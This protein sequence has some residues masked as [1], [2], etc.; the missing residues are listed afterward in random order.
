M[1]QEIK[2]FVFFGHLR[3][4]DGSMEYGKM[5]ADMTFRVTDFM[6][7]LDGF[8]SFFSGFVSP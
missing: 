5:I 7:L 3:Q 1:I 8:I 4:Q 6:S 2:I